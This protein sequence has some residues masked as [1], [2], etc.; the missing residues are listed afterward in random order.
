M[1]PIEPET[2]S[3]A[4]QRAKERGA[5]VL[6]VR[7]RSE[8][9]ARGP[10][11]FYEASTHE[12]G[13]GPMSPMTES[14]WYW[15]VGDRGW[16]V[17]VGVARHARTDEGR[18]DLGALASLRAQWA[19]DVVFGE[20]AHAFVVGGSA[21]E[22]APTS[23]R[24]ADAWRGWGSSHLW[25]PRFMATGTRSSDS[26]LI[27]W[28]FEVSP[29]DT[30]D[31]ALTRAEV[32]D[33]VV[34]AWIDGVESRARRCTRDPIPAT[35]SEPGVARWSEL[36]DEAAARLN[37][38]ALDKVVLARPI[39][40]DS[41]APTQ[42][43]EVLERAAL[44][45]PS[46][47]VFAARPPRKGAAPSRVFVGATPEVLT[48]LESGTVYVDALAGTAPADAPDD[49]LLGSEKD[50]VEHAHVVDFI[51]ESIEGVVALESVGAP[52]VDALPNVKH[53]RTPLRGELRDG[54]DVFTVGA[55]LHPTPAVCGRPRE[56][57]M[58]H[59]L[60]AEAAIGFER[61]WYAGALG[62]ASLEGDG[63]LRVA[64]RCA[65]LDAH[66]ADVFVGAGIVSASKGGAEV[67][68]TRMKA[69]AMLGALSG[70]PS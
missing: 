64:L 24:W 35:T 11:A 45:Y 7:T 3:E 59:L 16:M 6:F 66:G 58:A 9:S 26:V 14:N 40:Y 54:G 23:A 63:E 69:R 47:A 67:E 5:P 48:R 28:T 21:F 15:S 32:H 57:A 18:A 50:R 36:V 49:S 17:G 33:E 43:R 10:L 61:G 27:T 39:R 12:P 42:A 34:D 1:H 19:E 44:A 56:A 31:D 4:L 20:R 2:M 55:L 13:A 30:L 37:A 22:G 65:L 8:R 52:H 68:E 41:E 53:L 46:C 51:V 62:W 60:E 25:M 38:G 29:D 70:V